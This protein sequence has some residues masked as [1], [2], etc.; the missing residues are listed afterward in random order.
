M[1]TLVEHWEI[2][3]FLGSLIGALL[4]LWISWNFGALNKKE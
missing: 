4:G 3:I 2:G 1:T